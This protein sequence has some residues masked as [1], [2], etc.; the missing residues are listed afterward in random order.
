MVCFTYLQ[1]YPHFI[2]LSSII[3]CNILN[4]V[5][6]DLGGKKKTPHDFDHAASISVAVVK[7][8]LLSFPLGYLNFFHPF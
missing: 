6:V 5:W 3:L 1:K 7:I 4:Y 2:Q 8:Y